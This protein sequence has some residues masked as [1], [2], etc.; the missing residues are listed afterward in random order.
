M[1]LKIPKKLSQQCD[2]PL[3]VGGEGEKEGKDGPRVLV[4][5]LGRQPSHLYY[6]EE[7]CKGLEKGDE[8]RFECVEG[9]GTVGPEYRE[10]W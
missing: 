8:S 9:G 4:W 2:A 1:H 6:K 3:D 7:G 10:A 5:T